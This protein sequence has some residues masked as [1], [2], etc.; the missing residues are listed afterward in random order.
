VAKH[1][2]IPGLSSSDEKART[3]ADFVFSKV[4]KKIILP[5]EWGMHLAPSHTEKLIPGEVVRF[6]RDALA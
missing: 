1:C 5:L 3:A 4:R 6:G 2:E